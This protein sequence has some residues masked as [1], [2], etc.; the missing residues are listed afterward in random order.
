MDLRALNALHRTGRVALAASAVVG[1][2]CAVLTLVAV[3]TGVRPLVFLSGS[4]SPD[5]TTG[6]LG[7]SR[8]V[9]AADIKVGDVVT[10]TTKVDAKVTHR[11]VAATHHDDVVTLQL[12]GDANQTADEELY[13][14]SSAP[15]LM[16][17]V[18]KLG[19]LVNWLS[20]APGSYVLA[21]YV[22]LMLVVIARRRNVDSGTTPGRTPGRHRTR[23]PQ[24]L[25]PQPVP[26]RRSGNILPPPIMVEP[27]VLARTARGPRRA[28]LV[29]SALLAGV[30]ALSG[31]GGATWAAWTDDAAVSG[32]TIT[33]GTWV[34]APPVAPTV[35]S[36]VRSGNAI[37]LTWTQAVDPANFQIR[38]TT[39]NTTEPLLAG[40][41]RTATTSVANFNNQ[42]GQI[43]VVAINGSS[44]SPQS[45][46]YAFTGNGTG[47]AVCNPVP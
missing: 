18:P 7:F 38:Y 46:R 40:T 28:V 32:S 19:Y 14:V 34:V 35:T 36:C 26:T 24:V 39:P 10:V 16:F 17:A 15:R 47:N 6:S 42:T 29:G 9:D 27:V 8:S 4:M 31:F 11:V 2:A 21:L 45:N 3:L 23:E 20:H 22:A 41:V 5:V 30:L 13:R 33:S 44:T 37:T 12:K 25:I 43:W 1:A